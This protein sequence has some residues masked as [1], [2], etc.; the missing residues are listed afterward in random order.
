MNEHMDFK[1]A[2]A[3]RLA[4]KNVLESKTTHLSQADVVEL[5]VKQWIEQAERA[6]QP[7]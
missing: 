4:L 1:G 6:T 3:S 2:P 7:H 5:A